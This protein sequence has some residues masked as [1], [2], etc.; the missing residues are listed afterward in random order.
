VPHWGGL[1]GCT[2][3]EAVSWGKVAREAKMVQ[4]FSDATITIPVIVQALQS[5]GIR[6]KSHPVF[7]WGEGGLK[8]RY[9]TA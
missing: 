8:L 9:E 6:R 4:V 7:D 2:F 3:S 1:S 5:S